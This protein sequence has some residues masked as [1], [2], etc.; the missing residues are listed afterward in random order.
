MKIELCEECGV[1]RFYFD[2]LFM[3]YEMGWVRIDVPLPSDWTSL[4]SMLANI[5]PGLDELKIGHR[6]WCPRCRHLA[7]AYARS[8]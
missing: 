4:D 6:Y 7:P 1:P 5:P 3:T 8:A 2:G